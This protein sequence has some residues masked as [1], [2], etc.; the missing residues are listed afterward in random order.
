MIEEIVQNE[1]ALD[2]TDTHKTKA[3]KTVEGLGKIENIYCIVKIA[4]NICS[5]IRAFFDTE[6]GTCPVIYE[7]CIQIMDCITQ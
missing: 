1:R 3:K 7:L 4:A 2:M 5:F 6:S